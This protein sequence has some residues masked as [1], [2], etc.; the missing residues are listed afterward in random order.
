MEL[1]S[2]QATVLKKWRRQGCVA[3]SS[4]SRPPT[5]QLYTCKK[6]STSSRPPPL[7]VA[8]SSWRSSRPPGAWSEEM[9]TGGEGGCCWQGGQMNKH[10]LP[11][12]FSIFFGC[13][14]VFFGFA[15][16][17]SRTLIT[18]QNI[19]FGENTGGNFALG[20]QGNWA[21]YLISE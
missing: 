20:F 3:W 13:F 1:S 11:F 16:L 9:E 12:H 6:C 5:P 21:T 14:H 17:A 7:L 8:W 4:P 10:F 18:K 2:R 15:F 19:R